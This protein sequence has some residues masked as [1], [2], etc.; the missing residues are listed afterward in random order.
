MRVSLPRYRMVVPMVLAAFFAWPFGGG[1]LTARQADARSPTSPAADIRVRADGPYMLER[2]TTDGTKLQ[3]YTGFDRISDIAL[4]DASTVLV[5]EPNRNTISAM[6][7]D[8]GIMWTIPVRRPRC[9]QVLGPDRFLVCQDN[10]A[11]VVEVDRAGTVHWEVSEPLVDAAGAVRLPDGNTGV[12]E[13]RGAHHAVHV[14]SRDGKLLWTSTERLAQ[15]RGLALLPTGELVTS[16]FDTQQ[17]VIVHP[18]TSELRSIGFCCHPGKPSVTADG[19]FAA[20]SA[21]QQVVRAWD[22]NGVSAWDF[23]TPYPPYDVETLPDGTLLVSAYRS[24]DRQC[25][26]AARAAE[27]AKHPLAP[28]WLWLS[29]GTGL[30]LLLSATLQWPALRT[31]RHP[32]RNL[33]DHSDDMPTRQR[34]RGRRVRCR[35]G[36]TASGPSMGRKWSERLGLQNT[37]PAV[38]CGNAPGRHAIGQRVPFPGPSMP[39]C[40]TSGGTR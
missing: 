7:L 14:I 9:L 8:G 38:R 30:A 39:E 20:A 17:L 16:G 28:Y 36:R 15:P 25:L 27:R 5:A 23:K 34:H 33:A 21:E 24:P 37:V 40:S 31:W 1:A 6:A 4:Y 19:G 10:P 3:R 26:N 13:G 2:Y 18:F 11:S 32:F 22:E 12:V 29:V 35:L